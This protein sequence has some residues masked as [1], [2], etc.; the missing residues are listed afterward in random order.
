MSRTWPELNQI[1]TRLSLGINPSRYGIAAIT[2]S[3]LRRLRIES[4]KVRLSELV[5]MAPTV[6]AP[7]LDYQLQIADWGATATQLAACG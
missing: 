6:G 5:V 2:A 4:W 1:I 3:G 7:R